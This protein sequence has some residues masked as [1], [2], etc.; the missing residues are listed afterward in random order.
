MAADGSV[1][2]QILADDKPA[3]NKLEK[4]KDT[5]GSA[6][7][8]ITTVVAGASAAMAGL[9]GAAAKVGAE[10]ESTMAATSTMFGD[11][12]VDADGLNSKILELSNSTGMAATEIGSSLYK[13][14][15]AGIPVTEDMGSA[16]EYME[17]CAKLAKAGFTDVDTAVTA[18][19]KI[20][21]AYGM[22]VSEVG[23]VH[24][25][26]MQTQNKG[27]TTVNELG[28]SLAQVTPTAA[29]MSVGFDQVG[30]ALANMTA[31]GTPTAQATTQ[32]N[33][34]FAE[35]GKSGTQAQKG[36]E[37]ALE[38]TGY[39]GKSFQELMADGVPLNTVLDLMGDY[40]GKNGK[41]LLDMFSSI[42]GGKAALALTGENSAKFAENLAAMSTEAD[43]VDSA[44]SKATDTLENRMDVLK[45]S[46]KNLGIA[47]Y[48]GMESP[49][50]NAAETATGMLGQIAGA[51]SGGGLTAAVEAVGDVLAQLV[52]KL[53]NA[54]PTMINAGVQ[55]LQSLIAGIRQN[56]PELAAGA[57][58]IVA[59]LV[60]GIITLVPQLAET[61]I[62]LLVAL[63]EGISGALPTLIPVAVEAVTELVAGLL[64]NIPA[65]I[66]AALQLIIGLA[67]GLLAAIPVLL[68]SLPKIITSLV[69]AL[70]ESIPLIIQA[71]ID[72]LTALVDALPEIIAT[73]VEV[74][75]EIID[76]IVTAL[77]D[78]LPTIVQAGIDLLVALIQALPEI[79]T[80]IVTAL[81]QIT[82][83]IVD[84][85]VDNIPMLAQAGVD[86]FTALV[87]N[88]PTI[89][90]EILKAA[91]E[92]VTSLADAFMGLAGSVADIGVN[93]VTGIWDGISSMASWIGERVE[94][95]F[96]GIV[97]GV[98]DFLGIHSP[99]K[100]FAE[101][102]SNSMDGYG[103][104]VTDGAGDNKKRVLSAMED[105][106]AD[107]TDSLS[108][109][110]AGSGEALVDNMANSAAGALPAIADTAVQTVN[111]F[112][113]AVIAKQSD[114]AQVAVI[115]IN[116]FCN[117][118]HSN[119]NEFYKVGI[120][121]MNGLNE[122]LWLQGQEAIATAHTVADSIIMEMRRAMD[123]HSPSRKMRELVGKPAGEGF[124]VGFED[125]VADFHRRAAA[126]VDAETGKITANVNAKAEGNTAAQG[127]TK[128]VHTTDRTVEKV[129]GV[130]AKGEAG[131]IIR[132]LGIK[133]KAE[134]RRV[135]KS[136]DD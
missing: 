114:V 8:G 40:A 12:K 14:L 32:L 48:D 122:G 59:S 68:E 4:L 135:G 63:A 67:E 76:G 130:E 5:A 113:D 73:I 101:I 126:V 56:L 46:V 65:L 132:A 22:D 109:G 86:L 9:A 36:L 34:L 42:E 89:I 25:I 129:V 77:L 117:T 88:L 26:L 82:L 43:V 128:E 134:E 57:I 38:G 13:A 30:A 71:G 39:A 131:D 75:P 108:F 15:S 10:F 23:D 44:F 64:D 3:Q 69:N 92:I 47:V 95:F 102:G 80:M 52:T 28:A 27:I 62:Q 74:L 60:D 24:K 91:P 72:L 29:A 45:E 54:A 2:I 16:M 103:N 87:E 112:T 115:T 97:D 107:M 11:V 120:E 31:A 124:I 6:L 84:A 21:N 58:N 33:S 116:S 41:S 19:A 93:L 98:K 94:G 105:L 83:A 104:G 118:I 123:I 125:A 53:A 51:F 1:V 100:V 20:L 70:Y 127:V 81:P 18:T 79:I 66:D 55:L 7:K 119:R 90:A 85:L 99:S 50:K 49:L 133:L 78:N 121:A 35:L 61:A 37:A 17:S 111:T 136:L 96:G 110:G 106:T